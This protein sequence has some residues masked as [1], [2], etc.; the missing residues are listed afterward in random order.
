MSDKR[1]LLP[2]LKEAPMSRFL[3]RISLLFLG[4]LL[5]MVTSAQAGDSIKPKDLK[6]SYG[7]SCSGTAS[8]DPFIPF[9]EIG[10]VNCDGRDTCA[11]TAIMNSPTGAFVTTVLGH[12]TLDPNGIGFITYDVSAG[13]HVLYQLPIQFVVLDGG[14]EIRGLP[15]VPGFDVICN[16]KEQ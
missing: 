4:A 16:L 11:G 15:I 1:F 3:G 12:F 8:S 14:R 7:F 6:R 5:A 2:P 13:G 9:T 10:Q